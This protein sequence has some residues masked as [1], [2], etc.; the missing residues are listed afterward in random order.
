MSGIN[1]LFSAD[2]ILQRKIPHLNKL[3]KHR[4]PDDEG[5]VFIDS[6]SGE[7]KQYSGDDSIEFIKRKYPDISS[8]EHNHYNIILAQRRLSIIDLSECGHGP[9]CDSSGKIW[10]TYNGEIYNYIEL[11][12]EL[13]SAGWKFQ[14]ATD[15][16]VII[17]AY[18]HWGYDCLN[19]FNGMWAFCI[20][21]GLKKELLLSRDRFGVKP[22][23]Y[24]LT[25]NYFAFSSEIKPL[26]YLNPERFEISINKIPFFI[27][28]GN[29]L[30]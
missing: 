3:L 5:F 28:H 24:T 27:L 25:D 15:T 23:Y 26:I 13:E 4:G 10:I 7:F 9:T 2:T 18:L 12:E 14:T 22:L 20:W 30:N 11:R 8:A 19:H 16:E 1:G 21:D 17:N 6:K 29:R